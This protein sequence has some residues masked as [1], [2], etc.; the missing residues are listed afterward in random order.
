MT[1]VPSGRS[2]WTRW[3][4]RASAAAAACCVCRRRGGVLRA[5]RRRQAPPSFQQLTFRRGHI[6]TA[7]F[8]PDGQTVISSASWDG[9]PFEVAVDAARH[10][11]VNSAS[12]WRRLSCAR[13][14]IRRACR[15]REE[16]RSRACADRRRGNSRREGPRA[17]RGLG[18]GRVAR[19]R[20]VRTRAARGSSIHS[21]RS[22]TNHA[23]RYTLVRLSPDGALV[24][25]MEQESIRRGRRV[26]DYHRSQRR[27]R[28]QLPEVGP[29]VVDSLAW[30]PDGH[31]VWFT[32]SEAR[33]RAAI[34]AMTRDGRERIVHQ[35]DGVRAHP[36]H[37]TRWA[38]AAR[39]RLF[40]CGHEPGGLQRRG[41]TRSDVEGLVP[42]VRAIG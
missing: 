28:Q 39:Q 33:G 42:S 15:D 9:K 8:A 16:R 5:P 4:D 26:A 10:A 21:A 20:R 2:G 7:R 35:R 29:T 17:R 13:L 18:A 12:A 36:G 27:H 25:V 3:L 38:R 6:A 32:A 19:R 41:R 31:E 34:H 1:P 24:A 40:S 22:S 11:G 14:A 37:R 30:T 23:M